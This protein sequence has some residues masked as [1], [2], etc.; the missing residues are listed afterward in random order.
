MH[1]G[2]FK[3]K[4]QFLLSHGVRLKKWAFWGAIVYYFVSTLADFRYP[5]TVY[6]KTVPVR[7]IFVFIPLIIL[8]YLYH[9]HAVQKETLFLPVVLYVLLAAGIVHAY[10]YYHVS[11]AGFEFPKVGFIML[12]F[13]SALLLGLPNR[14]GGTACFIMIAASLISYHL[15]G[16]ELGHI[17]LMAVL[18]SI[19]TI[20]CMA[21]NRVCADILLENYTL[22]KENY[23]QSITDHLTN[24]FNRRYF[25]EQSRKFF[26]QAKRE[27]QHISLIVVDLDNFKKLND[28]AGHI[29]GD[30]V[31]I[32]VAQTLRAYCK[33]PLDFVARMGGDEFV[34]FLYSSDMTHIQELC[35]QLLKSVKTLRVNS[36]LG[37]DYLTLSIGAARSESL[38]VDEGI[39]ELL[40]YAD[41]AAYESKK[42]GK[43]KYS[44]HQESPRET[45]NQERD[46]VLDIN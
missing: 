46:E 39:E 41:L 20:I 42:S 13:Y 21:A 5:E 27:Q 33:R 35:E 29:Y 24:I 37:L 4:R 38:Q 26:L 28:A 16:E 10:V 8:T 44:I 1:Q 43:D 15:V 36:E 3:T 34:I 45:E 25:V 19:F 7:L 31:L 30:K 22:M 6:L 9:K 23:E 18:Y 2:Q 32:Q 11:M 40:H 14:V 17:V 12:L